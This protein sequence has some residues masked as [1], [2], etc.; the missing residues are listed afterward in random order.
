M[1]MHSGKNC[2][3]LRS[4]RS[5][6]TLIELLVVIAIIAILA[7]LLLPSMAK[8]KEKSRRVVCM[9]NLRQFGLAFNLYSDD[10]QSLLETT[11]FGG[12]TRHPTSVYVF[13]PSA[14]QYL[15]AEA[16]SPYLPGVLTIIDE[17]SKKA[18][19]G[20][21][22]WCPS[23]IQRTDESVQEEMDAWGSFTSSY[24]YFARVER[25]KPGQANRPRDLTENELRSDRLLMSDYLFHWWVTGSY[26]F[27]HGERG[28]READREPFEKGAP[29]SLAGLNQLFGD[30]HV[31][32]KSGRRMNKANIS[33]DNPDIGKISGYSSDT[34]FY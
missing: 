22:W 34:V 18:R 10:H 24:P 21:V 9:S 6:F 30:G 7:S 2:R 19:I 3:P 11:E 12:A 5:G 28:P 26:S 25:W 32:W 31:V 27:T 8:A 23:R 4:T 15:N 1:S 16:I 13:Q 17:N 20:S 33:P 29:L 14:N